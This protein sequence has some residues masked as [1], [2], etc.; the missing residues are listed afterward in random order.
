MLFDSGGVEHAAMWMRNTPLSLDMLFVLPDGQIA[1]IE[2]RM[3]P[4][5]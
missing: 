2:N 3:N 5:N 4:W 1:R